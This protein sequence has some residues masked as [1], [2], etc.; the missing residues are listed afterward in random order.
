MDQLFPRDNAVLRYIREYGPVTAQ[1][2]TKGLGLTACCSHNC[3]RLLRMKLIDFEP[4]SQEGYLISD[5][6]K[7]ALDG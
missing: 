1:Q 3:Q 5:A 7:E 6:G 4:I 2:I